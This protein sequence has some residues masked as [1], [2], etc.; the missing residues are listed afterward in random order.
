MLR[1]A[2][3]L[4]VAVTVLAAPSHALDRPWISAV[5]F[6]W[7][8]WDYH[9]EL[10]GWM[11]QGVY[12]QPLQGY[13]DSRTY[14]D[15]L[16]SLHVA[17]EWGLTHCFM[18][19]WGPGWKGEGGEPREATVMRAAEELQRRGYDIHMSFYQD[20]EDFDMA[21]FERNLDAGR[22]FR[23]YVENW[24]DSPALPRVEREPVYLIYSRNGRPAA[25]QN[26]EAS[27]SG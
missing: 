20:G 14:L 7:Y 5:Y 13:Y 15:N 24:G 26:N 8:T 25:T 23:F 1:T 21:D 11:P 18:D 2:L 22:H 10:G 19:Y 3:A 27:G 17:S 9:R 6:Y 16:K 4:A 12:N